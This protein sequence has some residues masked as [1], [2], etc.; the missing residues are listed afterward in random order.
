MN[1][2]QATI[3]Q[4]LGREHTKVCFFS[5]NG[6]NYFKYNPCR[7]CK[8]NNIQCENYFPIHSPQDKTQDISERYSVTPKAKSVSDCDKPADSYSK[9][10]TVHSLEEEKKVIREIY[11]IREANDRGNI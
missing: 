6:G 8:G 9:I 3:E 7:D 11:Q 2:Q 5:R 1:R 10:I 4:V